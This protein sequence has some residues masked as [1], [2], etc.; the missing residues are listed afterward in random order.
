MICFFLRVLRKL[1]KWCKWFS[2]FNM[3]NK[4]C[5]FNSF[6]IILFWLLFEIY[7]RKHKS[8]IFFLELEIAHGLECLSI[9]KWIIIVS[10]MIK[11]FFDSF[12]RGRTV[13]LG[14]KFLWYI[15]L[16]FWIG[17]LL[18]PSVCGLFLLK[19][20]SMVGFIPSFNLLFRYPLYH[21]SFIK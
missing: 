16:S 14:V 10:I 2:L 13:L 3:G 19:R 4:I 8:F 11:L 17:G 18:P 5:K 7:F 9:L 20:L 15:A 6:H 12:Q 21:I 1:D